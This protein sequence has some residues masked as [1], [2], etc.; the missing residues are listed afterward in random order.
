MALLFTDY[1]GFN[2]SKGHPFADPDIRKAA[3]L[4]L[5]RPAIAEAYAGDFPNG[6]VPDAG[7]VA[8]NFPDLPEMP[9]SADGPD[10]EHARALLQ[11]HT[12]V[13]VVTPLSK[14]CGF[15]RRMEDAVVDQLRAVGFE[16][17]TVEDP[18]PYELIHQHPD[19]Y[20]F[21]VGGSSPD[22]Y[23]LASYLSILFGTHVPEEWLPPE[24]ASAAHELAATPREDRD[25]K[26]REFLAG[27][28]AELVPATG[29]GVPVAGSLLSPR[30][31][32][33]IFP[34][35]GYG[36]DLAALCPGDAGGG[37]SSSSPTA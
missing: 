25:R 21:R 31:G 15:C 27:P 23:D 28:V 14:G 24:V 7:L 20:D 33:Q 2:A 6:M 18:N 4:A 34:P 16:V 26:A 12:P 29:I 36:V 3:A 13:H 19:R 1:V 37:S 32:C 22:W 17:E 11:G 8:S 5:D 10:L 9:F 35:F 30:L